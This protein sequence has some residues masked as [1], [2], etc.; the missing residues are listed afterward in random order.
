MLS[1]M[2]K[3]DEENNK[4]TILEGKYQREQETSRALKKTMSQISKKLEMREEELKVIRDRAREQH[5][6]QQIEVSCLVI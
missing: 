1:P 3:L 5:Q 4:V 2:R 6:Q